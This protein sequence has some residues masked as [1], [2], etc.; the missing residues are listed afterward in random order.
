MIVIE[1][2]L[3]IFWQKKKT[4]RSKNEADNLPCVFVMAAVKQERILRWHNVF[5]DKL[6][7]GKLIYKKKKISTKNYVWSY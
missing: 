6:K 7:M 5:L 2:V 1:R 4:K 3:L